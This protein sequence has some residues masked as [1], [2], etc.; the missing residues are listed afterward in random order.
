MI[1]KIRDSRLR[2]IRTE[3][4][5]LARVA[6][7]SYHKIKLSETPTLTLEYQI[8]FWDNRTRAISRLYIKMLQYKHNPRILYTAGGADHT[9]YM[10]D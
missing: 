8:N 7:F 5:L 10:G 6:A 2:P 1:N 3:G 9:Y 4:V